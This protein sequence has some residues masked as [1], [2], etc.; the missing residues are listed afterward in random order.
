MKKGFHHILTIS[1]IYLFTLP[2]NAQVFS[3]KVLD[4]FSQ[5]IKGANLMLLPSNQNHKVLFTATNTNGKFSLETNQDTY[6]LKVNYL[7]YESFEDSISISTNNLNKEIYLTPKTDQLDE[8]IIDYNYQPI[9][10]KL[11]TIIVD[12][13][14][15]SNGNER[16]LKELLNKVPGLEVDKNGIIKLNGK[17][18]QHFLVENKLFFGGG[19]KLGVENIPADAVEQIE[20]LDNFTE[21][22]FLKDVLNTDELALNVKLKEDKK[23]LWFGEAEVGLGNK[24]FRDAHTALFYYSPKQT[25]NLIADHNTYG[26]TAL[27]QEDILRFLGNKSLFAMFSN[28]LN[29][30]NASLFSMASEKKNVTQTQSELVALNYT[31]ESSKTSYNSYLI[32]NHTGQDAFNEKLITYLQDNNTNQENRSTR[33]SNNAIAGLGSFQLKKKKTKNKHLKYQADANFSLTKNVYSQETELENNSFQINQ[34]LEADFFDFSQFLEYHQSHSKKTKSTF[35]INSSINQNQPSKLYQS[36]TPI[37]PNQIS[38]I[39]DEMYFLSQV[40]KITNQEHQI[41]YRL[42][43]VLNKNLHLN[44]DVG[45][46]FQFSNF[47]T[48]ESQILS[49]GDENSLANQGFGNDMNYLLNNTYAGAEFRFKL[50]KLINKPAINLHYY[51]FQNSQNQEKVSINKVLFEP[52]WHS[53]I[54]FTDTHKLSFD[55]SWNNQFPR[56][57]LIA[58]RFQLSNFNLIFRGNELL[59]EERFH[60]FKLH[61]SNFKMASGINYFASLYFNRKTKVIREQVQIDGINQFLSPE[62][63]NAP[64]NF[65]GGVFNVSKQFKYLSPFISPKFTVS[66]YSQLV[67]N[68]DVSSVRSDQKIEVGVHLRNFRNQKLPSL[69]LSYEKTFQQFRGLTN[70]NFDTDEIKFDFDY[71][72]LSSFN[73]VSEFTYFKN[74]QLDGFTEEFNFLDLK[75]SYQKENSPWAFTVLVNNA[76]DVRSISTNQFQDFITTQTTTF[77]LPRMLLF[78]LG[79][80]F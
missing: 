2:L 63:R 10:N 64:E 78:K 13:Q 60:N 21:V 17:P 69:K 3:G 51:Y 75:L 31:K 80:R 32:L 38:L 65:Y 68:E 24:S 26:K 56:P 76:L 4:E 8:V 28:N 42:Y 19:S 74:R 25:L 9:R 27:S 29:T 15:F 70:T 53:Q 47:T 50:G 61:A 12:I 66:D 58:N 30:T 45:N 5:P 14:E 40:K 7:G 35:V 49:S 73:F 18:I 36:S 54:N 39:E 16:K 48:E 37:L 33:L 52:K 59:Q 43:Q 55:Y 1:L 44:L 11:D 22:E 6:L 79:Y 77:V 62:L 23:K 57:N 20:L 71:S 67:N 34:E 46:V 72:F 41:R